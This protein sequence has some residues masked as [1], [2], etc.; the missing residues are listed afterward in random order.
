MCLVFCLQVAWS[1]GLDAWQLHDSRR[2]CCGTESAELQP[3]LKPCMWMATA[4]VTK[5]ERSPPIW[6]A[7][8]LFLFPRVCSIPLKTKR[9]QQLSD[10]LLRRINDESGVM[11]VDPSAG[12]APDDCAAHICNSIPDVLV[13]GVCSLRPDQNKPL[14]MIQCG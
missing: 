5:F 3:W 13:N 14:E 11:K 7:S 2:P 9:P 10:L 1:S 8:M 6:F 4:Q 12:L